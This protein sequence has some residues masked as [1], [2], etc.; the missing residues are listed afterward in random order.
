V[1]IVT[2]GRR[3]ALTLRFPEKLTDD[4]QQALRAKGWK[5]QAGRWTAPDCVINR[6]FAE[7]LASGELSIFC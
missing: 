1:L 5:Y 7:G 4:M 3:P 2:D 6:E